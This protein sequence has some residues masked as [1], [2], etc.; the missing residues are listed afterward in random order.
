MKNNKVF[1]IA[2]VGVNHNGDVNLAKKLIDK[3]VEAGVDA[4]KF[5]TWKTELIVT[6]TAEQAQYQSENIGKTESQ[7]QMLKRLELSFDDFIGL[8]KY[9]DD[10]GIMFLSTADEVVSA[11]FLNDLQDTFK[12]GSGELTNLPFLRHI[13]KYNKKVILSTGMG[14]LSEI[15]QAIQIL[16]DAGTDRNKIS[17][18]HANTQYPTPME[19]VN[20]N[21][22]L[23]IGRA[24]DLEYGYSDHTLGIEVP[25]ASVALGATIIEKHF[26]LDKTMEGPDHKASLNPQEL[27]EMVDAIR[28]IEKALGSFIKTPSESEKDNMPIVRK[29]IVASKEI[30]KGEVF[31]EENITVKRPGTGLSPFRW[32]EVIGKVAQKSYK[33]DDM[34]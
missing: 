23:T 3:A 12:I 25:I 11:D 18:L 9:C 34:I 14:N 30:K 16:E 29:S 31:S 2:E 27:K 1:V 28:N 17:L 5:Q 33:K 24:F 26:T 10:K 6:E 19:D 13:G 32:D 20:L 15:E 8:K 7:Y 22:M 4:V 21:A